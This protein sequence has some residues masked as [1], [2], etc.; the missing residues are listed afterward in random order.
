MKNVSV[1]SYSYLPVI[2]N[3]QNKT[4]TIKV[5]NK[6][7][8]EIENTPS[9]QLTYI[10]NRISHFLHF[11]I[12][13][14]KANP[15]KVLYK[16]SKALFDEF[17]TQLP[18]TLEVEAKKDLLPNIVNDLL[19]DVP[20]QNAESNDGNIAMNCEVIN[21]EE[22]M[23]KLLQQ[24]ALYDYLKDNEIQTLLT[25][26]DKYISRIRFS[27]R[28]NLTASLTSE[29]GA[30]CIFDAKTFMCV[31][32][33]LD[34][35]ERIVSI[36]VTFVQDNKSLLSVKYDAADCNYLNIH[37]LYNKYYTEQD[38]NKIWELYKKYESE[39]NAIASFVRSENDAKAM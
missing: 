3:L 37:V 4:L 30:K 28:D 13:T 31:R 34:L 25:N 10:Y 26:T 5:W 9:D 39:N 33:S 6:D 22:E 11:D 17:F 23:Y 36:V 24:V 8:G 27:D 7:N 38:F 15:Q 12:K 1:H 14:I 18:N 16:M 21:V 2:F 32:N 19:I 29:T 35:V 20:L